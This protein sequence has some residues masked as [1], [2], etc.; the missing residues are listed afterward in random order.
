MIRAQRG[1][2]NY[3]VLGR[4]RANFS[5]TSSNSASGDTGTYGFTAVNPLQPGS[6]EE[7]ETVDV[8]SCGVLFRW[9]LLRLDAGRGLRPARLIKLLM[10]TRSR[11]RPHA[12]AQSSADSSSSGESAER[13]RRPGV[14]LSRDRLSTPHSG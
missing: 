8:R 6:V 14:T 7:G 2:R 13:S 3:R 4:I 9:F 5:H 12:Q 11:L 10:R 1:L